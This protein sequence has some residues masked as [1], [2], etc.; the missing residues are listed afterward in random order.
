[1]ADFLARPAGLGPDGAPPRQTLTR[2][3]GHQIRL[4]VGPSNVLRVTCRC[5]DGRRAPWSTPTDP[6][7]DDHWAAYNRLPHDEQAAGPFTPVDEAT[8]A[9]VAAATTGT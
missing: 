5:Q 8:G 3:E 7:S 4:V 6:D 2:D 9:P 1:M